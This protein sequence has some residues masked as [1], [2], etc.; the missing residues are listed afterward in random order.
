MATAPQND[1]LRETHSALGDP[2]RDKAASA[3][4][5]N[6][7][8]TDDHILAAYRNSW[9]AKKI[10]NIPAMDAI[11]KGREW[12]A[13]QEQITAIEA[14]ASRLGLDEKIMQASK[15]ARLWGGAAIY[16]GTGDEDLTKPLNVEAVKRGGLKY[17]TV[18]SRRYLTAGVLDQ[19]PTSEF[20]ARP[21]SYSLNAGPKQQ[22]EIHPSR[23]AI[24][25]GETNPDPIMN[26]GQAPGWDDSVLQA[27]FDA[28]KHADSTSANIASLVFEANI[29][30]IGVPNL[31][32]KWVTEGH[33]SKLIE[34]FQL[35]AVGKAINR[36]LMRDQSEE[37]DRKQ[38][39][40][41]GLPDVLQQFLLVV[42]GAADIP[43]TRF[44]G[45]SPS[46]LSSTGEGDMKNY[47]DR[48]GAMQ[49]LEIAPAIARLDECLIRSALGARP[50]EIFYEWAP[51]EQISEK[52]RA[53]MALK[54]AQAVD[55]ISRT[56]L[57]TQEELRRAASNRMIESG[58]WPG[59][60]LAMA[61]TGGTWEPE[62]GGSNDEGAE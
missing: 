27:A 16:I 30:V 29:D 45:Q 35:A 8:L 3:A 39:N 42:S 4:Y 36:I 11:R 12:Q 13:E 1:S 24:F 62:L 7:Y 23:L 10:V 41:A 53:E 17:L 9:I 52:D 59:L 48:I 51:L 60:E 40:F 20:F 15:M 38:I 54:D 21:A 6:V 28:A 19:D 26:F 22:I 46:G 31:L 49:S 57:F 58:A 18:L 47:Y 37:Y 43:L 61:E 56:G 25:R 14:E 2:D 44:L 5:S 33:R 34:R 50:P 55:T 32:S